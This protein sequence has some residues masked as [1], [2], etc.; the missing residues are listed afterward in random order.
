MEQDFYLTPILFG[1]S[2]KLKNNYYKRIYIGTGPILIL[3]AINYNLSGNSTLIIDKSD[4]IG[5]AWKHINF[6]NVDNLENA[7]H[8]L[9]PNKECY[10]FLE[11]ILKIKLKGPDKKFFNMRFLNF[12]LNF[13]VTNIFY[14]IYFNFINIEHKSVLNLPVI[15]KSIFTNSKIDKS[16][17]PV[18]GSLELISKI[19]KIAEK[20]NLS[21]LMGTEIKSIKVSENKVYLLSNKENYIAD[22]LIISHGFLPPKEFNINGIDIKIKGVKSLR[23]SLHINTDISS[24]QEFK[25]FRNKFSQIIFPK[26]S[27]IKYIHN[28][29]QFIKE[30]DFSNKY[31]FIVVVAIK[32]EL[33]K[34]SEVIREVIKLLEVSNLI[35]KSKKRKKQDLF[36]QNIYLPTLLNKDLEK[37]KKISNNIIRIMYTDELSK[38]LG[39][40]SKNWSFLKEFCKKN[41]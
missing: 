20:S 16:K 25:K 18:N 35:P 23:A 3:D 29:S 5:G 21:L 11:K 1:M 22:E 10:D 30:K 39:M 24:L 7:V 19:K 33:N 31:K 2:Y 27:L 28:L 40:Y 13:P 17:Y 41:L 26:N 34:S 15:I 6:C 14:R 37:I 32:N 9:L 8:Y 38:G 36:W 4:Q 12:R